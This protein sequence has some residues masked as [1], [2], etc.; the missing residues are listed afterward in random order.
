MKVV[1]IAAVAKNGVIGSEN[2]LPWNIPEDMQFFRQ[3]TKNHVVIMG[4]KTYD[5]MGK[6]LPNRENAVISRNAHWSPSES[7]AGQVRLFSS[8]EEAISFYRSLYAGDPS[9]IIFVI[10]GAQIY[11]SVFDQLDEV[12]LTEIDAMVDGD[13]VFPFYRDASLQRS[14]FKR[15]SSRPGVD[16]A[17]KF[18]YS[19]N[20]Y[21]R[22]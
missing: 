5:S 2:A 10:G 13:A 6:P 16:L 19:F 12:W 3:S 14:D 20:V 8:A 15:I 21:S 9:K 17:S 7:F 1:A 4:R 22:L 18:Q 11:E